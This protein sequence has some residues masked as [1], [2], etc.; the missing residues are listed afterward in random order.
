[1]AGLNIPPEE[2]PKGQNTEEVQKMENLD[3]ENELSQAEIDELNDQ[4]DMDD[5]PV[6][7]ISKD[8]VK[9]YFDEESRIASCQI[10]EDQSLVFDL[11]SIIPTDATKTQKA[12][13]FYGFKQWIASNWA[14]FKTA[15]DKITSAKSDY[16]DLIRHGAELII[17]K[18]GLPQ[19]K[20]V[21][22]TSAKKGEY[23]KVDKK[24]LNAQ[25]WSL[26]ELQMMF[27]NSLLKKQ[28]TTEM[29]AKLEE[30]TK[31][32][33]EQTKVNEIQTKLNKGK[34]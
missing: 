27:G 16:D 21:G 7:V 24:E 2:R 20:I 22:K 29:L 15:E 28:M 33:A 31:V 19:M 11:S 32:A 14:A 17:G 18:S 30:L 3:Q 9:W 5:A 25:V 26:A 13:Y 12:L 34:K 6:T 1:M 10:G 23:V 4:E 8:R